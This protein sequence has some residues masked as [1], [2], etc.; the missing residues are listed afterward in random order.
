MPDSPAEDIPL[1]TYATAKQQRAYIEAMRRIGKARKPGEPVRVYIS[2]PP[3]LVQRPGWHQRR[4][5]IQ[6]RLPGA[7]LLQ[8]D[9]LF[10]PENYAETWP[11]LSPSLDGMVVVAPTKRGALQ[12]SVYRLGEVGRLE[13]IDFVKTGRPVLLHAR[14]LGLI[15]FVDCKVHR[16]GDEKL[17]TKVTVPSGWDPHDYEP[18]LQAALR[19][20][21]PHRTDD[22]PTAEPARPSHLN[23]PFEAPHQ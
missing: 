4:G 14:G 5:K 7:Q 15:P 12:G 17:R 19:A 1:A 2:V 20:L 9:D 22:K 11:Q 13:V 21:R 16:V 18:T 8:F 6:H 23:R 3:A 10:T